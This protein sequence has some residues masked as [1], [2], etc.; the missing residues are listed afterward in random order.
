MSGSTYQER[1]ERANDGQ[2][3]CALIVDDRGWLMY[4]RHNGDAGFSSRNPDYPGSPDDMTEYE[5]SNGQRDLYPTCWALPVE[6][7]ERALHYFRE[8]HR[9][10]PFVLWHNDSGDGTEIPLLP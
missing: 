9:P 3:I 10:A 4:L 8:H 5:L 6:T 2:S 7:V 1:W